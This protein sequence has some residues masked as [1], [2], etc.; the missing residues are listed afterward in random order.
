MILVKEFRLHL[1]LESYHHLCQIHHLF[2]LVKTSQA[3]KLLASKLIVAELDVW[4]L[5]V[6]QAFYVKVVLLNVLLALI[7]HAFTVQLQGCQQL[8]FFL[9]LV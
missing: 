8:P 7:L 5:F 2:S 1:I 6:P 3:V 4:Q 9:F